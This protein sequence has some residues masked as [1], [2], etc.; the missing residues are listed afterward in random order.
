MFN[1]RSETV[2]KKLSFAGLIKNGQTCIFAVEGYYEWTLNAS[3]ADNGNVSKRPLTVIVGRSMVLC[4]N[5]QNR[6]MNQ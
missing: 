4:Q 2:Y 3:P 1:A 6:V 5:R